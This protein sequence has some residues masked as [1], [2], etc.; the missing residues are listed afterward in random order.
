MKNISTNRKAYHDFKIEDKYEVGIVLSGTE[1]KALRE[2]RAN[3]PTASRRK[4]QRAFPCER[5]YQPVFVR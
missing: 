4:E 1:V 5:P 2:G 3:L